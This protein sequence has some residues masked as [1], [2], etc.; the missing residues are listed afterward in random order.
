MMKLARPFSI[1]LAATSLLGCPTTAAPDAS[2]APDAH[3]RNDARLPDRDAST[4][5]AS[6]PCL[7]WETGPELMAPTSDASAEIVEVSGQPFVVLLG[8]GNFD[9]DETGPFAA[10]FSAASLS[11]SLGSFAALTGPRRMGFH[12]SLVVD[13]NIYVLGGFDDRTSNNRV[14]VGRPGMTGSDFTMTWTPSVGTTTELRVGGAAIALGE[15]ANRRIYWVGGATETGVL[16]S[17]ASYDPA[18]DTWGAG[19]MLPAP[20][21]Y[22]SALTYNGRAYVLGGI[23]ASNAQVND[24]LIS[25]HDAA[26]SLT[27]WEVA[28]RIDGAP[29][30]SVAFIL[31]STAGAPYL[32]LAGGGSGMSISRNV[33]R[34]PIQADGSLGAFVDAGTDMPRGIQRASAVVHGNRVFVLGGKDQVL[35]RS[36]AQVLIGALDE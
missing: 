19:P 28:A 27:G 3:A 34:A 26:G 17:V 6:R 11:G 36:T 35:N 1:A 7:R 16:R 33:L 18:T 13:G 9:F 20:R 32:F 8:G 2:S 12:N 14:F 25:T 15:G 4:G 30:S 24:V 29:W 5:C 10:R 31:E 22:I 21:A 23:N